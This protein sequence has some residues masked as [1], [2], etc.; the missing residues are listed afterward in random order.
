MNISENYLLGMDLGTTN[1][2]AINMDENGNVIASASRAND[3]IIPDSNSAEQD[4]NIWWQ[5]VVEILREITN[6]AGNK[7]VQKIKGISVSS[8]TVT[9]LPVDKNG[10]PLRNAII[11]MDMRSKAQLQY[12]I[13]QIGFDRYVSMIGGQPDTGFLPNKILWFKENEPELFSKTHKI[14]QV[15]SYINYKLTGKMTMDIDQAGKSQCLDISTLQWSD[16]IGQVIGVD[17]NQLLPKPQAITDIIGTVSEEAARI[18]GLVSGIPVVAGASD[19]IASMYAIGLSQIGDAG[20]SSGTSSLVFAGSRAQTPPALPLVA[21]P[22]TIGDIPYIFDAPISS[23]GASLKWYLDTLGQPEIDYA[24]ANNVNIFEHLNQLA[25]QAEPGSNGLIFFPYLSGE[26]APLWN[27]YAKGMLIGLSK[28]THREEIIRAVFEGTA[29][30]LR[31]VIETITSAGGEASSLRITGGGAK[32][33]TWSLIK[34]SVLRMPVYILDE[35]SGD[36]P[37]GDALIAGNGV[38]VFSDLSET[39]SNLIHIKEVI[40][41]VEEWADMYDK[42]YPFYLSMYKH[43][44]TDLKHFSEI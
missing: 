3:L 6:K 1:V 25:L 42:I 27:N 44:D 31:H 15:S 12:I 38:G 7:L 20:E 29:F 23:S 35:K 30:A 13:D 19:A 22:C 24:H 43:L 10:T 39:M 18:T 8:Q 2:K 40:E 28:N 26:R 9:M 36:V 37:F 34:A 32:S 11:W 41:P 16:E 21:K 5:N 14:L 17:L 33:R 4:A